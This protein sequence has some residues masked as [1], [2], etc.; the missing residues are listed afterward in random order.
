MTQPIIYPKRSRNNGVNGSNANIKIR[1]GRSNNNTELTE[2]T[3]IE[4]PRLKSNYEYQN[5]TISY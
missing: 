5:Q 3:E 4:N 1:Q 2:A